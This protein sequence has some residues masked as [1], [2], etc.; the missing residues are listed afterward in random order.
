MVYKL[1]KIIIFS[2]F[3]LTGCAVYKID[4]QQGNFVEQEMLNKLA[5]N[6]PA[7]TVKF[8]MGTPLLIDS[9]N[10][11]RW[12]YIYSEQLGRKNRKQRLIS[13]FF[14]KNQRL[15]RVAGDVQVSEKL[16]KKPSPLPNKFD[17]EPIL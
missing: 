14:D 11:N 6:M 8:I 1:L 13:L 17:I 10:Q 4:V 16:Q 5:L 12:D 7:K 2:L 9:F 3:L 15:N